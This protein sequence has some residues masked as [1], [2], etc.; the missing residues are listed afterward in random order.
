M[1]K[2]ISMVMA[3]AMVVSLVPATAF[4]AN[5]ATFKV[6]NDQEY[7]EK[8]AEA[9]KKGNTNGAGSTEATITGPEIQLKLKDVDSKKG[10]KDN[11]DITLDFNNAELKDA[12]TAAALGA[13]GNVTSGTVVGGVVGKSDIKVYVKDAAADGDDS[14]KLIV[15]EDVNSTSKAVVDLEDDDVITINV[16]ALKL[17]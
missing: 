9:V 1:K 7:T 6:V 17:V 3:A 12:F 11:F 13:D 2:F 4:A 14:V 10:V 8:E 5:T 15:Q 16:D